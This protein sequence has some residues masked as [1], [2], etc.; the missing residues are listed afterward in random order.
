MWK[1]ARWPPA[2]VDQVWKRPVSAIVPLFT[3]GVTLLS[4]WHSRL[5]SDTPEV[6]CE[7]LWSVWRSIDQALPDSGRH[8]TQLRSCPPQSAAPYAPPLPHCAERH[9]VLSQRARLVRLDV[10]AWGIQSLR[11][12]IAGSRGQRGGWC[13]EVKEEV[14]AKPGPGDT[15]GTIYPA[16]LGKKERQRINRST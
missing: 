10:N 7:G 4:L 16:A 6:R 11:T 2:T 14:R 12:N 3:D 1:W 8:G 9:A 13:S 5:W 15:S